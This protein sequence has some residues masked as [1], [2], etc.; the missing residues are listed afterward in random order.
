MPKYLNTIAKLVTKPILARNTQFREIHNGKTCYIMGEGPSLK[1]FD[2][3]LFADYPTIGINHF[4]MH[5]DIGKM[6]IKYAVI[7]E[8]YSFYPFIYNCY[9]NTY[10]RNEL[11]KLCKSE[12]KRLGYIDWFTS[13]SNIFAGLPKNNTFYMHH[14]G[15]RDP[16]PNYLD[17]D[18]VF[19]Y[20]RGG[21]YTAI[22]L[23]AFMGFRKA[24]LIGCDYVFRPNETGYFWAKPN[25]QHE[26]KEI[27]GSGGK[28]T[29]T[30][31]HL[32]SSIKNILEISTISPAGQKAWIPSIDYATLTGAKPTYREYDEIVCAP[33]LNKMRLAYKTGQIISEM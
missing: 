16:N 15:H 27:R 8:P 24:R 28:S 22:G 32:F 5:K 3:G 26:N 17:I 31:A 13:L 9:S 18:G 23:A 33:H 25:E 19:S 20:M 4:F 11:G 1:Y 29:N 12:I 14:F 21:L 10:I 2:L 30:Y 6:N 7:P